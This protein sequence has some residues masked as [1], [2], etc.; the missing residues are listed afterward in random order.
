[1][2]QN[3][4]LQRVE[5]YFS[6]SVLPKGEEDFL[7]LGYTDE[8]HPKLRDGFFRYWPAMPHQPFDKSMLLKVRAVHEREIECWETKAIP[9]IEEQQP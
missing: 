9:F 3:N 4:K 7:F 1:M 2:A 5:P 8:Q 6:F